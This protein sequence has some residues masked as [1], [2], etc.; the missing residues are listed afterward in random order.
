MHIY[1][2]LY[3]CIYVYIYKYKYIYIYIY[4]Y[5]CIYIYIYIYK[6]ER[7]EVT[8]DVSALARVLR[9]ASTPPRRS[10]TFFFITLKPR[11]E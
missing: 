4:I 8:P 9:R 11:V 2:Y 7:V 5:S 1:I 3:T 6:V 10:E